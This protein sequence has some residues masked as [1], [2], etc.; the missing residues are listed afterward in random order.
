MVRRGE[1]PAVIGLDLGTTDI[2]AI[3]FDPDGQ[4]VA[5]AQRPSGLARGA[6]GAAELDPEAVARSAEDALA[7]VAAAC[8]TARCAVRRIGMSA[9][10]HSLIPVGPD[11]AALAPAMT[12]ADSRAQSDADALWSSPEGP[13]IYARTGTPVHAMSPLAKL[14]WMRRARPDIFAR[15]A[16]FAG[17]KEWLWRRWFGEWVVELTL[18]SA[19]GLYNPVDGDWDTEALALAGVT[20]E[21][22]PR[23][24]P[25]TYARSDLPPDGARRLGLEEGTLFVAGGSDGA[26]ANLGVGALEGPRLALTIGTSLAIRLGVASLITNPDTR[27]FC[28]LVKP[29][30][31]VSGAASNSGGVALEWLYRQMLAGFNGASTPDGLSQALG[32]A[33]SAQANGLIFLPYIAG[34][35]APLWSG[36][37]RGGLIGLSIEHTAADVLRAGVEGVLFNAAWLVE[38]V[39]KGAATPEEVIATGGVFN[40]AWIGQVASD[41]LGVPLVL[42]AN[43]DASARGA[44]LI[45]DIAAGVRT[46]R[47]AEEWAGAALAE[48]PRLEP[49][50]VETA[51]YRPRYLEF[52]R[53]AA[54][55]AVRSVPHVDEDRAAGGA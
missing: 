54:S 43:V 33:A 7:E 12:W 3:A 45:A 23:V 32:Q 50:P 55:L 20:P 2:K 42:A 36:A 24:V 34:E 51:R 39:V 40:S 44:A 28:Y 37:T 31:F 22:L 10:M 5:Q 35:R 6:D 8:R 4:P 26:M 52:R 48:S 30:R 14:L 16:L 29:G 46:W 1:R 15:A 9:A 17:L 49:R 41:I 47:Q 53:L 21:R 11:G 27:V 18:A 25:T 13:I 19:T 38:Q